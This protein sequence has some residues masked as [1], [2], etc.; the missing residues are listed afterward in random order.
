MEDLLGFFCSDFD[1]DADIDSRIG[2]SGWASGAIGLGAF[3]RVRLAS[4]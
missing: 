4:A 3:R 1:W 2:L